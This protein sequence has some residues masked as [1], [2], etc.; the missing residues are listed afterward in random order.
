MAT[1]TAEMGERPP[2]TALQLWLGKLLAADTP[3]DLRAV[4]VA[5]AGA[6]V[7]VDK[8]SCRRHDWAQGMTFTGACRHLIQAG[9]R[10][11]SGAGTAE[12]LGHRHAAGD[13]AP[14]GDVPLRPI[15]LPTASW[16]LQ[17]CRSCG[18]AVIWVSTPK[19]TMPVNADPDADRGN[20][21]LSSTPG[22]TERPRAAIYATPAAAAQAA[23]PH[24]RYLSHFA[25]CPGADKHRKQPKRGRR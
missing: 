17:R 14:A 8:V 7:A 1:D 25:T 21:V 2:V 3:D 24:G 11:D 16:P 19:S 20:V 4:G 6:G 10:T 15:P 9:H 22:T 5:G 12:W 13:L 18:A 23:P